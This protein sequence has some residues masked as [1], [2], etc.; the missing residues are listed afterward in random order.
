M[1]I[2]LLYTFD[3]D[4]VEEGALTRLLDRLLFLTERI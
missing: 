2:Y 3:I 4:K 1:I